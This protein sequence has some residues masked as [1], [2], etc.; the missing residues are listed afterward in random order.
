MDGGG[1]AYS[2]SRLCMVPANTYWFFLPHQNGDRVAWPAGKR[3]T[4]TLSYT[5]L[6]TQLASAFL[7]ASPGPEE[8]E[9]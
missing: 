1:Q 4:W 3:I 5:S 8:R 2:F 7:A 9:G 6:R